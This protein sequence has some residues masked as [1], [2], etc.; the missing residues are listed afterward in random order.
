MEGVVIHAL[1]VV[2][3]IVAA[4]L[5]PVTASLAI[6][7]ALVGTVFMLPAW[8]GSRESALFLDLIESETKAASVAP[9]PPIKRDPRP[10]RLPNPIATP[11]PTPWPVEKPAP[12]E[13]PASPR[14]ETHTQP[15]PT[16]S[17]PPAPIPPAP[18]PAA[19][20][21]PASAPST[22][23]ASPSG[24]TGSSSPFTTAEVPTTSTVTAPTGPAVAALPPDGITQRAIPR[25]GYQYRPSY[26]PSARNRGIQ[27]TTLLGVLVADDGRVAEVVVKE[28]A[29]HPDL[30]K[31]AADAVRRWRFE[32][33][34]R[35]NEAVAMWV[36]LPVEFRLR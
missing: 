21:P 22:S 5:M 27:G 33:A 28:S 2:H 1:E 17:V 4:R 30:D 16:A 20:G 35:G 31:A 6:H 12:V 23:A 10:L 24:F 9:P 18:M 7:V 36:V 25:G 26:P 3:R 11:L 8:T 13:T 19:S 32:P 29:G 15:M 14:A 34:R